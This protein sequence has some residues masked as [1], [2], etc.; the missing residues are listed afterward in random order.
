[1]PALWMPGAEVHDLGD[2]APTDQQYPPRAIA[3]IT[4][5]R[6]ATASNPAPWVPYNNLVSYFAGDGAGMAPHIVWDPFSGNM[7]QFYPADS[8]SKSV[9]DLAGATRTNRAGK[10]CIQIEAVYFPY[11]TYLGTTYAKLTD[12]PG[13]GWDK[14]HAWV[15]SWG[16]PDVWP[17]G[18]PLDF[19]PRR[20]ETI[21]ETVGG[22]YAHAHVPE[23]DHVDPGSWP[24]TPVLR[25]LPTPA[26]SSVSLAHIIAAAKADPPA[27]QGH[28]TYP[29]EVR[30]VEQ[31]LATDGYLAQRWVDG[32]FGT[33]T[34]TA[35]AAY[36]RALGYTGAD[37]DGIPGRSSL[38][39]LGASHG[40]TVAD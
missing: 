14:L 1:M 20:N 16:V 40:F 13:I 7:T 2:H 36:Q 22:W 19:T 33:V 11:C 21:W 6:N 38:Q 24:N 8:R 26:P 39:R 29:D 9:V 27:E 31:A 4:W 37:A 25:G 32:S 28:T 3:H 5:D 17:M 15:S 34:I 35:Y 23:N 30:L 18:H 12:T 10:V